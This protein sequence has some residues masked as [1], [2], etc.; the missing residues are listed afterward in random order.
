[1]V[2]VDSEIGYLDCLAN[3]TSGSTPSGIGLLD[4]SA[5]YDATWTP[6]GVG[7]LDLLANRSAE[8]LLWGFS[9][10]GIFPLDIYRE[11]QQP[12]DVAAWRRTLVPGEFFPDATTTGVY[13]FDALE[14]VSSPSTLYVDTPNAV[15][16]NKRFRCQVRVRASGVR[17]RN[18]YFE[19]P[20]A[21]TSGLLYVATVLEPPVLVEDCTFRPY[22]LDEKTNG[23]MV[24]ATIF[25]RC[26]FSG[27]TDHI[28][29]NG[30]NGRADVVVEGCWLH[31]MWMWSPSTVQ[32]S[33][34]SHNDAIQWHGGKGLRIT[35]SR[36]EATIDPGVANGSGPGTGSEYGPRPASFWEPGGSNGVS[37]LTG[38]RRSA[39]ALMV[40]PATSPHGE[41]LIEKSWLNHGIVGINCGGSVTLSEFQTAGDA[42]IRNNHIG[43]DWVHTQNTGSFVVPN[44][45][46]LLFKS[47]HN[48]TITGNTLWNLEDPFDTSTPN[49]TRKNG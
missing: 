48:V 16:E 1:M 20:A 44:S 6:S 12:V 38:K 11:A 26:H 27:G 29:V 8:A 13:D 46:A 2:A 39:T 23:A 36:I 28:G 43:L 45:Y 4:L 19:G 49:N 41:L 15:F 24:N 5:H 25:R 10:E 47:G 21:S 34:E 22:F 3:F 40:S 35:G 32:S 14:L 7:F 9:A 37:S 30:Q 31:D 17:F 33:G 18:C 42:I